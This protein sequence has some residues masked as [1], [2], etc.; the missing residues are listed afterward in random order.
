MILRTAAIVLLLASALLS[1][2][3]EHS[4]AAGTGYFSL[5]ERFYQRNTTNYTDWT[6]DSIEVYQPGTGL[7]ALRYMIEGTII[8]S[9]KIIRNTVGLAELSAVYPQFTINP[10]T[11]IITNAQN[12]IPDVVR[13]RNIFLE[14][15]YISSYDPVTKTYYLH[16]Y[17]TQNGRI[18]L[19]F[20]DTLTALP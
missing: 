2:Q 19:V 14:P 12:I 9:T 7:L 8:D 17:M 10:G 6:F 4:T 1:C 18:D 3:K 20:H 13:G 15:G 5:R 16:Y 11:N